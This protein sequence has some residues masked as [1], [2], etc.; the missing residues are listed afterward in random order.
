MTLVLYPNIRHGRDAGRW[1]LG[2]PRRE[3]EVA[4]GVRKDCI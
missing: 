4:E 2:S 3:R 1:K